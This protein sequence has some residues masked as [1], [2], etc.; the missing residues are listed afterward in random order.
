VSP[1]RGER[2]GGDTGGCAGGRRRG[3]GVGGEGEAGCEGVGEV[4][5]PVV[6]CAARRRGGWSLGKIEMNRYIVTSG[7]GG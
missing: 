2:V 6:L 3:G 4:G 5:G 1:A 7:K